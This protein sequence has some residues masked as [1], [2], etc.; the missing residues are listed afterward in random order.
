MI[1]PFFFKSDFFG[2]R[3]MLLA[4][5]NNEVDYPYND[6]IVTLS[7]YKY[8]K[9]PL[10]GVAILLYTFTSTNINLGRLILII[11]N[12]IGILIGVSHE[13]S[14][15]FKF[16]DYKKYSEKVKSRFVPGIINIYK[17]GICNEKF[18]DEKLE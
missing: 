16:N 5:K 2:W 10:Y 1:T 4:L 3:R 8:C 13:E 18:D 7:I 6:I 15:L 17:Y 9:H 12:Y 11:V 14:M